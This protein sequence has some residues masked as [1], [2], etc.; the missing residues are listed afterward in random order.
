MLQALAGL[1]ASVHELV[2]KPPSHFG[3]FALLGQID[4]AMSHGSYGLGG[5]GESGKRHLS[6]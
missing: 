1:L 5:A 6:T 3:T 2:P 4:Q